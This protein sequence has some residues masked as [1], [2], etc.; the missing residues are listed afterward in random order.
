MLIVEGRRV[1]GEARV[2][3]WWRQSSPTNVA[4]VRILASKQDIS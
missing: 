4:R 2:T 3:Q 1:I